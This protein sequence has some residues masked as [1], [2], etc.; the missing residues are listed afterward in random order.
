ML[1]AMRSGEPPAEAL[2][3][4]LSADD[5]AE[6]RQVAAVDAKGRVG[7]HTGEQCIACAGHVAG[8][9]VSCQA[10]IMRSE[11][12]W[13]AMLEAFG[14][15]AGPLARR[16][17][18]ALE[19]GEDVGGDARGRQS[20]ALLVVGPAGEP[21]RR[22][23]E[24]RVEDHPEPLAELGRL[25][26][27]HEAYTLATAGD[28]RVAEGRHD[29]AGRLY[30]LAC[31]LAPDSH[32]LRFWAGLAAAQAGD[33]GRALDDVRFAVAAEPGW[34]QVLEHLSPEVAPSA[35]AVRDALNRP[36]SST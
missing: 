29:E 36:R 16:L 9:A 3:R 32:E 31:E 25:L 34:L 17:L 1:A 22:R 26:T 10:N 14:T 8:E 18:A 13:P 27:V 4:L 35:A 11:R 28:E 33:M 6:H 24:L 21:W 7:V 30:R 5:S 19:A 20:A 15:T 23:V 2:R 12:V